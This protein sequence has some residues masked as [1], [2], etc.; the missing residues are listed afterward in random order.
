MDVALYWQAQADGRVRCLLCPHRCLIGPGQRGLCQ[1][2]QNRDGM[3]LS[4]NC[5]RIVALH[6]DPVEKKPLFHYAPGS[7]TLSLAA[8]GCNLRCRHCQNAAISQVR[9]PVPGER[10][11]PAQLVAQARASG[12]RS[13][14]YTYTEPTVFFETVLQTARAAR[15][16][17]LDN[18]LVSN[19]YIAPEPLL[20]LAP[21]LAAANI[22][23]KAFSDPVYRQ[24][25][26]ARLEPVL[27]SLR[28]LRRLG[29]WLEVTTLVIPGYNDDTQQLRQIA[30]FIATEL[31]EQ[32][33]WHLSAFFPAYQLLNVPPT[34]AA[35]L[36]Q[37][38]QVGRDQG[39][40]HVYTGNLAAGQEETFC[41]G[42]G[43][44]LISRRGYRLIRVELQ[45]GC[46][47]FCRTPLA[48][49]A[50]ADCGAVA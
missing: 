41:S 44:L 13:L 30:G 23:L 5:Q 25:C 49:V 26:G 39:L 46:C 34:P 1:V 10:L 31:G 12:C 11:E 3:L 24:L 27:A 45:Q 18:L 20:Q 22:D 38:W 43:R 35:T 36:Q 47:R 4:L 17:G 42:C 29:V 9:G 6:V 21:L 7:R 33:P 28:L 16:A 19:G 2:R 40:R 48:G 37:A 14:A 15:D 50:L 32:T 8:V